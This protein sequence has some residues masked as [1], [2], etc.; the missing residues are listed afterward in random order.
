[1]PSAHQGQLLWV[2]RWRGKQKH[3]PE[4]RLECASSESL[5]QSTMG[6]CGLSLHFIAT[7]VLQT[8]PEVSLLKLS[9]GSRLQKVK[10]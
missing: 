3:W 6:H 4:M 5:T 10:I 8:T 2:D 1:M 7:A 9:L